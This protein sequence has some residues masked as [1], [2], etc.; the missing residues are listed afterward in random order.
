MASDATAGQAATPKAPPPGLY[1]CLAAVGVPF[2]LVGLYAAAT[3]VSRARL[4]PRAQAMLPG[5]FALFFGVLGL[6]LLVMGVWGFR[7][8]K[9]LSARQAAAPGQPWLWRDDWASRRIRASRPRSL[10]KLWVFAVVWNV[11]TAPVYPFAVRSFQKGGDWSQLLVL[12]FPLFGLWQLG[13]VV[14]TTLSATRFGTSILEL[15]AV[16]GPIG[17]DVAG[18]IRVS[19]MLAPGQTVRVWLTC[20]RRTSRTATRGGQAIGERMIWQGNPTDVMAGGQAGDVRIP[21]VLTIPA[22][23]QPTD[24]RDPANRV[25]WRVN[26]RAEVPGLDYA[27]TFDVPVFHSPAGAPASA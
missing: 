8:T 24:D 19:R 21:F 1:G 6:Q 10:G 20:V 15:D 23:A 18:T 25:V 27:A 22:D 7:A 9:A 13:S 11:L 2:L 16:P 14:R 5:V 4:G 17:G 26:A 12:A 3:A